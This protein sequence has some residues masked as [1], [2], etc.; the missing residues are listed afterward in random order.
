MK[1]LILSLLL[2]G[3]ATQMFAQ[4]TEL[5]EVVITAVNYKYLNSVDA[6]DVAEPVKLLQ[7]QVAL[8][9]LK[10]S[11]LYSDEYESYYVTFFIPEGKIV[12][13]YDT[14]GKVIRTIEKFKNIKLPVAVSQSISR[15]FPNWTLAK[16]VYMVNYHK[17][18][19]VTKMQYKIRL[20][21]GKESLNVKVDSDGNFM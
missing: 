19:G 15:R 20:E 14:D 10:N 13:A 1:K 11:D 3:W 21:N 9:D 18:A 4:I 7:E 8:Y 17:D 5:P 16:D 2:L 12:A 6:D